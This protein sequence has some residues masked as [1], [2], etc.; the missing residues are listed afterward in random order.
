MAEGQKVAPTCDNCRQPL[1]LTAAVC[2]NCGALNLSPERQRIINKK[3]RVWLWVLGIIGFIGCL[4]PIGAALGLLA[5][6]SGLFHN[7]R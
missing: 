1:P 4:V 5:I 3:N 2:P 7:Y 6:C